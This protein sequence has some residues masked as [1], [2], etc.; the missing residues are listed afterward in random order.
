M[1]SRAF[2][3]L[4]LVTACASWSGP[5]CEG[6]CARPYAA[7]SPFN[8]KLPADPR[9]LPRSDRVVRA[10]LAQGPVPDL[11][12]APASGDDWYHPLYVAGPDDPE[13]RVHCTE[14]WGRCEEEGLRVPLPEGARPADS[15]DAHLAVLDPSTGWEHDFWKVQR[16]D[17]GV[18]VVGWSG[19]TRLDGDGLGSDATAAHFGLAAG[20]VRTREL[21]AGR[22]EHALLL[23]VGCVSSAVVWPALG[24]GSRCADGRE[25]PATGQHL[26]L[27]L[28]PGQV[29]GLPLPAWKRA[30][31]HALA[32]YGGYVGDTGG[33]ESIGVQLESGASWTSQGKADPLVAFAARLTK[34]PGSGVRRAGD[35]SYRFDLGSGVDWAAHLQVVDPC[36]SRGTC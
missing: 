19:R 18:L 30:I 31:L 13:V 15:A 14:P 26:R 29:D 4:V 35:A 28:S 11:V 25:G 21:L 8:T 2:L 17:N 16:R 23:V 5:T 24:R 6:W 12:V 7:S 33:N 34:E 9:L 32:E 27:D 22:V 1:L 36:V 3:V 10:L 20:I